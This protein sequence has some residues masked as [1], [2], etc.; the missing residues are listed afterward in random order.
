MLLHGQG[1]EVWPASGMPEVAAV[2]PSGLYDPICIFHMGSDQRTAR[3]F[4]F[5]P[6]LYETQSTTE[7]P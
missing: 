4:F 6:F 3:Y 1:L 2:P 7:D 5:Y